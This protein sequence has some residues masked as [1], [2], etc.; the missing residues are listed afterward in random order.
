MSHRQ[1]ADIQ[2]NFERL[3]RTYYWDEI[4]ELLQQYPND[5]RSLYV[6]Y[7]DIYSHDQDLADD[8][9]SQP[10]ELQ[11]LAEEALTGLD[12]PIDVD[13]E[14]ATVRFTNLPENYEYSVGE[15]RTDQ[16]GELV[17]I[18]GQ[19]TKMTGVKPRIQTAVFECTRCGT[20]SE[21]PQ[22]GSTF[23]DPNECQ[24]CERQGPFEIIESR[25]EFEDYQ[26]VRLQQPPEQAT[27][28]TSQQVD[29]QLRDDITDAAEP[30]DR[31]DVVGRLQMEQENDDERTFEYYA[32]AHDVIPKETSFDQ[33]DIDEYEDEIQKIAAGEYGDPIDFL[34]GCIA[35]NIFG[36]DH[37]KEAVILQL[38]SGVRA[39][40]PNGTAERGD[41]HILVLGDPSVGKSDILDA[42]REIA[43]RSAKASGKGATAAGLTAGVESDDFGQER[44]SLSAG[45]MVIANG[46]VACVDEIDKVDEEIRSSLHNT[47]E[48]QTV[49]VSKIINATLPARTA[50][51]AAGNPKYGRFDDHEPIAEQITLGPALLSRFDLLFMIQD[52]VDEEEDRK[53]A[54][55]A[56]RMK[57]AASKQTHGK[58]MSDDERE[59]IDSPLDVEALR[60]YIAYARQNFSPTI[61]SAEVRNT[62]IDRFVDM[63]TLGDPEDAPIPVTY[64]QLKGVL[65]I[66]E[67][68]AKLRLSNEVEMDD[69]NRAQRLITRSMRD[70]GLDPES[71]QF[72]AD[73]IETGTSKSQR[74][75]VKAVATIISEVEEEYDDCAPIDIVVGRCQELGMDEEKVRHEISKLKGKGDVYEPKSDCLRTV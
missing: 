46:G 48:S 61:E 74:D 5:S 43:P 14:H 7:N 13:L 45:A 25:S 15:Y 71:G 26:V 47:L 24:G 62:I 68:S 42:A 52:K 53:I 20:L 63:R 39:V 30:G 9:R 18:S 6:D 56:V 41:F 57:T 28:G 3:Y 12:K 37:I 10:R 33:I 72:D 69:I 60:A 32:D 36:Y 1:N 21:I 35:P 59:L 50:L 8:V 70:V 22:S 44:F 19:I 31:V 55:Q 17:T 40:Y 29:V 65:R 73:I 38:A 58:S 49:E 4:G 27:N 67:A 66:A 51:L 54:S 16:T 11:Q 75:R 64:R 2:E 23:R 34:A